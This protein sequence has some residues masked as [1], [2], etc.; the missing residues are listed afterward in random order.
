M[1]PPDHPALVPVAENVITRLALYFEDHDRLDIGVA[2]DQLVIGGVAT[3]ADHPVLRD[4]ARRLHDHQVGAV[5][6]RKGVR[7]WEVEMLL[8]ALSLDT[9]SGDGSLG[10]SAEEERPAWENIAVH[11]VG[12]DKLRLQEDGT[13]SPRT[14]RAVELWLGLAQAAIDADDRIEAGEVPD[15]REVAESIRR[16]REDRG[17]DQVIAGYL[18]QLADELKG[19]VSGEARRIRRR[20]SSLIEELDEGSLDR[21][22]SMG[23]DA[24]RR[25]KL[26]LDANQTLAVDAVMKMLKAAA[27]TS[28][29]TV[30]T[31][32]VRLLN[33]LSR[34]A[35]R[36]AERVRSQ[37]D[38][39]LRENVDRL[40]AEWS[41][42]DPNPEE[43]TLVLDALSRSDAL[44]RP[45]AE[46]AEEPSG[47]G[48]ASEGGEED[49]A[50]RMIEMALEVEAWGPIVQSAVSKLLGA[51][52][53]GE[54]FEVMARIP[55]SVT[56]GRIRKYVTAPSQVRRLLS[57][58]DVDEASLESVVEQMGAEAVGPL[59]DALVESESRA[60]RRKVFDRLSG[61]E[62]HLRVE[63]ERR[64]QDSRWYVVRNMLALVQRLEN[65]PA[66]LDLSEFV[67][68][69]DPRVRREAFPLVA[70]N[71]ATRTRT[72]ALGLADEDERLT[73]MALLELGQGL[74]ETLVP[75]L[76]NRVV[77]SDRPEGIRA[78]AIRALRGS[79]SAL[80]RSA[81]M[82][83]VRGGRTLFGRRKLAEK[84]PLL[85]AAL[86]VLALDWADD[87]EVADLLESARRSD[88]PEIVSAVSPAPGGPS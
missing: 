52:R 11:G 22:V 66:D 35:E 68:H 76:V 61:M 24:A 72:L 23:G 63:I 21:L 2:Q 82:E 8:D 53:V 86:E 1:Y 54:L 85:L 69:P 88:D 64:L 79:D 62:E 7:A 80:A 38:S 15:E 87:A 48:D 43:Y 46:G 47:E 37:A 4:L 33:K 57:G 55:E 73:R 9:E 29:Q 5:S 45:V 12:Y 59:M 81:L 60:V 42:P 6:F 19:S 36:G 40:V 75:T 26:V 71:P 39:A 10:G 14:D 18:M 56:N 67:S 28:E 20:L 70:R 77:R 51:G 25:R 34:H 49:G 32:M 58:D 13:P 41:L 65:P 84:S 16:H 74:P 3:D 31:S 27:S 83:V 50:L 44:G 30:S 78:L 17:Y